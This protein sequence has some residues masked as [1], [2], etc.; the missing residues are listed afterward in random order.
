MKMPTNQKD[1]KVDL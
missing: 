1:P